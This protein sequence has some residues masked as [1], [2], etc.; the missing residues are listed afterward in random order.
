MFIVRPVFWIISAV[1]ALLTIYLLLESSY[2]VWECEQARNVT[3]RSD[4]LGFDSAD[5]AFI[6]TMMSI[7][8]A[9]FA[10]PWVP[11]NAK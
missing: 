6:F 5:V 9:I 3:C 4:V 2:V 7:F 11:K 1:F 8:F 10:Y